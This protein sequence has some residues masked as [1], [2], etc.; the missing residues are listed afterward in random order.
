MMSSNPDGAASLHPVGAIL[1]GGASRRFGSDKALAPVGV[2]H[3]PPGL[4]PDQDNYAETMGSVIVGELRAAGA[5][6][7]V[8]VGGSAGYTLGVPVIPDHQPG[9][10]P[11]AGLA[12]VLRWAG[13]GH[14][15][16]VPCDLPMLR[17]EHLGLLLGAL[18]QHPVEAGPLA[19]IALLK[20]IPQPTVG[21]WPAS[22]GTPLHRAVLAG[23]RAMRRSLDLIPWVGV[24]LAP[25]ALADADDPAT[26]DVLLKKSA[27]DL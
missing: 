5:D 2:R 8:A 4:P 10:G 1:T 23:D 3:R 17:A 14:V 18:S 11:L 19:A 9:L 15:L 7:V 22:A 27:Q 12:S 16:V 21:C 20:G 13:R 24:E 25:D 6:P 26:L